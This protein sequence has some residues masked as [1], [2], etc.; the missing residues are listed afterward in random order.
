M[1]LA[2]VKS[3]RA[4]VR[5]LTAFGGL[6]RTDDVQDGE[7]AACENLSTRRFPCLAPREKREALATYEGASAYYCFDGHEVVCANGRL[8]FDGADTCAVTDGAKQFAVV[9]KTLAVFPDKVSVNVETGEA[10]R[11]DAPRSMASDAALT[12]NGVAFPR[13]LDVGSA[14]RFSHVY[15]YVYRC[16]EKELAD[17]WDGTSW[18]LSALADVRL[19]VAGSSGEGLTIVDADDAPIALNNE[20]V[21]EPVERYNTR[22]RFC[23]MSDGRVRQLTQAPELADAF[24]VGDVVNLS[25]TPYGICDRKNAVVTAVDEG[26]NALTFSQSVTVPSDVGVLDRDLPVSGFGYSAYYAHGLNWYC[27][28]S[29]S[30]L[31]HYKKGDVVCLYG[32]YTGVWRPSEATWLDRDRA[33]G[34]S[35]DPGHTEVTLTPFAAWQP[36]TVERA[37]PDLDFVCEHQ[38]RLWGVENAT[39]TVYASALGEIT[40][41]WTFDGVSTDSYQLAVGGEGDFTAICSYGGALCCFRERKLHKILGGYPAEYYASSRDLMGVQAGCHK[42]VVQLDGALYYRSVG[43]VMRFTGSTASCVSKKLGEK[44]V[45]AACG[46][47]DGRRYYLSAGGELLVFDLQ[48]GLWLREDALDVTDFAFA[49]ELR[50]LAGDTVWRVAGGAPDAEFSAQL[51]PFSERAFARKRYLHLA[52]EAELGAGAY[53]TVEARTD[54]GAWRAVGTLA[55]G[56]AGVRVLRFAPMRCGLPELR[57][58]GK[59]DVA[60]LALRRRFEARSERES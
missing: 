3:S 14:D 2:T 45:D 48:T 42:S 37:I 40:K 34:S 9:G 30:V 35:A 56:T 10:K 7:L 23:R 1:K 49:G 22:G 52:L 12:E 17:A 16:T 18:N 38:N 57:L 59:G 26:E 43:G 36:V 21:P 60:V 8:Y 29:G 20:Y 4:V 47:A 5:D 53:L 51:V 54:G 46:G 25:G 11:M 55:A 44:P 13:A 41:F 19:C 27:F 31:P 33:A 28:G 50:M 32:G 24:A 15:Y 58:R 6:N 39:R